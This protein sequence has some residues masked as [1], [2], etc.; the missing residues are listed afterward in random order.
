M[1][2]GYRLLVIFIAF[3]GMIG[4][5]V[6]RSYGTNFELVEKEY[7]KSELQYQ[8]VIDG[9]NNAAM[10]SALPQLQQNGNLITLQL[11]VEM[12]QQTVSGVVLFYCAYNSKNDK[13]FSLLADKEGKQTFEPIIGPGT[14][15]VKISWTANGKLYY[16]EKNVTVL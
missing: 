9:A 15:T 8:H 14:Y 1:G 12:Q 3:A 11:P 13:A 16:S 4:Y 5:L 2:W 7:Y 6:Y 10:L